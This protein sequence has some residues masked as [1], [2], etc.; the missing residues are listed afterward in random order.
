MKMMEP[1]KQWTG[2]CKVQEKNTANRELY[3]HQKF[4]SKMKVYK[5][6]FSQTETVRT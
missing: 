3:S 2:I 6:S 5:D 1:R 4:I